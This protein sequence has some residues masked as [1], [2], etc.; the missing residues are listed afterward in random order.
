MLFLPTRWEAEGVPGILVEEKIAGLVENV[1]NHNY[2]AE[3]VEN[4]RDGIVLKNITVEELIEAILYVQENPD[5]L[6]E[7]K[8]SSRKSADRYYI[9][10]YAYTILNEIIN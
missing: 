1:K 3:I 6:R 2:N 5:K 4:G 9:E 7:M 8:Q 10:D